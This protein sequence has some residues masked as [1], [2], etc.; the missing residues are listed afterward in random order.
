MNQFTIVGVV[1]H[2]P[3]NEQRLMRV[4]PIVRI[5][6][7]DVAILNEDWNDRDRATIPPGAHRD[8]VRFTEPLPKLREGESIYL[9]GPSL[10]DY[11]R[12]TDGLGNVPFMSWPA[13]PTADDAADGFTWSIEKPET[14]RDL[15]AGLGPDLAARLTAVMV[16]YKQGILSPLQVEL[17]RL[18]R[19]LGRPADDAVQERLAYLA[20]LATYFYIVGD[21]RKA[22][23]MARRAHAYGLAPE[24]ADFTD[25]VVTQLTEVQEKVDEAARTEDLKRERASLRNAISQLSQAGRPWKLDAYRVGVPKRL[26][27]I[28]GSSVIYLTEPQRSADAR[29]RPV[30]ASRLSKG[31]FSKSVPVVTFASNFKGLEQR[32]D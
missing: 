30:P 28:Q 24:S 1:A 2:P 3:G 11:I 7:R 8:I 31:G 12:N 16:E 9:A 19:E 29:H 26:Q 25:V 4:D 27:P 20:R 13:V 23:S 14:I 21:P 10:R 5:D 32:H 15:R 22:R 17:L 18:Y 6:D